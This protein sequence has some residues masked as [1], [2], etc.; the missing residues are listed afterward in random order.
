[1]PHLVFCE[2]RPAWQLIRRAQRRLA[3]CRR[4]AVGRLVR[5]PAPRWLRPLVDARE[6]MVAAIAAGAAAAG[7]LLHAGVRLPAGDSLQAAGGAGG[8]GGASG[9]QRT[10]EEGQCGR[11]WA[12]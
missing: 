9:K 5:R 1:M 8:S 7:G 12:A 6:A 2:S 4:A 11:R 3:T 10:R